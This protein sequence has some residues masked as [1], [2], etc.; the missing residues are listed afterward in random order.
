MKLSLL[1]YAQ[2]SHP[3]AVENK[4]LRQQ[5]KERFGL[6]VRRLDNFTL[7]ALGA[8]AQ[9]RE[10]L[11]SFDKLSLISCASYFSIELVQQLLVDLQQQR[12]MRP[13]D[14]VATVGNAANFYIANEFAI[15]AGNLFLGANDD[16]ALQKSLLISALELTPDAN[17]AVVLVLWQ[18]NEDERSCHVLLLGPA[19]STAR[20]LVKELPLL[21]DIA[22][23]SLPIDLDLTKLTLSC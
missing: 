8:V 21:E 13:L 7:C 16:G 23:L 4:V 2:Y 17:H 1:Q 18:E 6:S 22:L 9:I 11:S 15:H 12:A 14:F 10:H 19:S 20:S 5:V 3:R